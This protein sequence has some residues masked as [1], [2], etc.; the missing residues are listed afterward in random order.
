MYNLIA[1]VIRFEAFDQGVTVAVLT[2][3]GICW[4][5]IF[6]RWLRILDGL[7]T[8]DAKHL[9][10]IESLQRECHAEMLQVHKERIQRDEKTSVTLDKISDSLI[11]VCDELRG[12]V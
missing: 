6:R 8:R 2:S 9:E 4:T 10:T 7:E 3:T 12:R 1:D 11:T 5:V